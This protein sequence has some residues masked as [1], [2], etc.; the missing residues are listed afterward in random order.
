MTS[1]VIINASLYLELIILVIWVGSFDIIPIFINGV[2][3]IMQQG[4]LLF[5]PRNIAVISAKYYLWKSWS[6][7]LPKNT[8][9]IIKNNKW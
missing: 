3:R 4:F 5:F 9:R 6:P 1:F 2:N 7:F 8:L